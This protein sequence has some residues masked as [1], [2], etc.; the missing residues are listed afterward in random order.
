MCRG[1]RIEPIGENWSRALG[2]RRKQIY[3]RGSIGNQDHR[4]GWMTRIKIIDQ[5]SRLSIRIQDSTRTHRIQYYQR[6]R[7]FFGFIDPGLAV[8]T[9][10]ETKH[11]KNEIE[12]LS[13]FS[14]LLKP[15]RFG[16]LLT[17]VNVNSR[18]H[19]IFQSSKHK[20]LLTGQTRHIGGESFCY[21]IK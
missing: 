5:D 13:L 4:L 8:R 19:A 9:H 7:S 20:S 2:L 16:W 18:F 11:Y 12:I 3:Y 15:C 17:G 21:S 6:S 14:L 1:R 10:F